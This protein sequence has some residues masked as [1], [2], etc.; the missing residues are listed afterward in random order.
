[1]SDAAR[2]ALILAEFTVAYAV[3]YVSVS[4]AWPAHIYLRFLMLVPLYH[5]G[6]SFGYSGGL[7]G[8]LLAI[9]LMVPVLPL[10]VV[11]PVYEFDRSSPSILMAFFALFGIFAGG[12]VGATRK[13]S[14]Y[15]DTLSRAFMRIQNEQ[16][17]GAAL[18]RACA[19]AA[20]LTEAASGAV[21]MRA[22]GAPDSAAWRLAPAF[23][24]P[25]A[26][27]DMPAPPGCAL[28]WC[29]DKNRAIATNSAG[30]DPRFSP[31]AD[32][33]HLRSAMAVPVAF[34]QSV[35]GAFLLMDRKDG[36]NFTARDLAVARSIAETAGGAIHNIV[37]EQERQEEKLREEQM[38]ELFSRFVSSSVADFVLENPGL[39][40][41]R[42]QEVSIL[43]SDIRD[44]TAISERTAPH[45][46][47][48]HLNE[49]FTAMVDVIFENRGAID[50]FIGDCIIAYWGAPAPDPD[51]AAHAL[52]AAGD[53]AR[54]LD[55]LNASWAA[56][57]MPRFSTGIAVHTC[58]V[59]IGNLGDE[60]KKAFTIMG[61][62]VDRAIA[63]EAMTKQLD[64][65]VIASE[66]AALAAGRG[67]RLSEIPDTPP[68]AGRIFALNLE[69]A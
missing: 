63:L 41:G 57:G 6:A 27:A 50:K 62:E 52:D 46:L 19:E 21:L 32:A 37:H 64:A 51:H 54:A 39:L 3:F 43:V 31:G 10:A 17:P 23:D 18:R 7:L 4:R 8:G 60:R 33:A 22:P 15:V 56:R 13:T 34:E 1:M 44:F 29:A 20:A 47:V 67:A 42:W 36:G 53:M 5:A 25:G 38:R 16:E 9:L 55:A 24:D 35:Y 45:D 12:A 66:T 11:S 30:S 69:R 61:E 2:W 40:K 49:Y 48:S 26:V 59:L 58:K 68:H 14:R 28:A 65:R